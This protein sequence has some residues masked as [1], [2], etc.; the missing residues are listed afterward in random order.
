MIAV[1]RGPSW[2]TSDRRPGSAVSRRT[3]A[4]ARIRVGRPR[5]RRIVRR[6]RRRR[7]VAVLLVGRAIGPAGREAFVS[8]AV[9]V[10]LIGFAMRLQRRVAL[11][12]RAIGGPVGWRR[13]VGRR[14]WLDA[15]FGRLDARRAPTRNRGRQVA[16]DHLR[17]VVDILLLHERMKLSGLRRVYTNAYR[18]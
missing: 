13:R 7:L 10:L 12:G 5:K 11:I 16:R 14:L 8:R 18:P 2:E 15:G 17:C 6:W 1:S 3:S 9:A 4:P